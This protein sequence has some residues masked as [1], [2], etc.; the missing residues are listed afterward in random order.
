L[1]KFILGEHDSRLVPP[2]SVTVSHSD[3][4]ISDDGLEGRSNVGAGDGVLRQTSSIEINDVDISSI[5]RAQGSLDGGVGA[6]LREG[7]VGGQSVSNSDFVEVG[8]TVIST[9]TNVSAGQIG[10]S[11]TRLAVEEVSQGRNNF[12]IDGLLSLNGHTTGNGGYTKFRPS[13]VEEDVF[14]QSV[15]LRN[16]VSAFVESVEDFISFRVSVSEGSSREGNLGGRVSVGVVSSVRRNNT[17]SNNQGEVLSFG[18]TLEFSSDPFSA[19]FVVL[20]IVQAGVQSLESS[21]QSVVL[22]EHESVEHDHTGVDI[23]SDVTKEPQGSVGDLL[24]GIVHGKS[25]FVSGGHFK[26]SVNSRE[27][28]GVHESTSSGLQS[29]LSD[30]VTSIDDGHVEESSNG[31]GLLSDS[32]GIKLE[33]G[34]H[35]GH[36]DGTSSKG[37]KERVALGHR[38]RGGIRTVGIGQINIVVNHLAPESQHIREAE[39]VEASVRSVDAEQD[40]GDGSDINSR[41]KESF[42]VRITDRNFSSLQQSVYGS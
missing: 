12:R 42:S 28:G 41:I 18:D 9:S 17:S 1:Y 24:G 32:V 40:V 5:S 27:D 26:T 33:D 8:E 22:S 11:S 35:K 37:V 30:G 4:L 34:S 39:R 25:L 38:Q 13:V 29:L 21:D 14:H 36:G 15:T 19:K 23:S 31:I 2:E 3:V 16:N 6:D 7:V 20:G 10:T